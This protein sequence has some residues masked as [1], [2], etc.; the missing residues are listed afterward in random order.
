MALKFYREEFVTLP[1]GDKFA[2]TPA[3]V[4]DMKEVLN[5]SKSRIKIKKITDDIR[6]QLEG[7]EEDD[8]IDE[9]VRD[10]VLNSN[11]DEYFP[12]LYKLAQRCVK[13]SEEKYRDLPAEELD[14]LPSEFMSLDVAIEI[15]AKMID[16]SFSNEEAGKKKVGKPTRKKK[17]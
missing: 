8:A 4:E 5:I 12:L 15:S 17:S 11:L 13:R 7:K 16:I 1:G 14:E 2:V 6:K 3:T 10:E 9:K